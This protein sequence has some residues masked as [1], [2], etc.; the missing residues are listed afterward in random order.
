[1]FLNYFFFLVPSSIGYSQIFL[2]SSYI[3]AHCFCLIGLI[4]GPG[5]VGAS[6]AE[7]SMSK[8]KFTREE[9]RKSGLRIVS[10]SSWETFSAT[11]RRGISRRDVKITPL[12]HVVTCIF[13]SRRQINTPLPRRD[14]Y[15]HVATSICTPL[16]HVATCIFTSQR[17]FAQASVTS[18]RHPARRDVIFTCLCHV[19]M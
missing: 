7:C 2:G 5:S 19:A 14:V 6:L 12:F 8:M 13:T 9:S 3:H 11:S 4:S 17:E 10:K 1:M 16:C 18:R 15:L